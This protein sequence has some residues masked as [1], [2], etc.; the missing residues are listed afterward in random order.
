M[1]MWKDRLFS[2]QQPLWLFAALFAA[3]MVAFAANL[4]ANPSDWAAWVQAFGSI[5]A[6]VATAMVAVH[7]IN[8]ERKAAS[9]RNTAEHDAF[10]RSCYLAVRETDSTLRYISKQLSN[11]VGQRY[12]LGPER[13]ED[14]QETFRLLLGKQL[15]ADLVEDVLIVQRELAYT[16]LALKQLMKAH[17]VSPRRVDGASRRLATVNDALIRLSN[18]RAV[19]NWAADRPIFSQPPLLQ[20]DDHAEMGFE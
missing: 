10:V 4:P 20:D 2:V 7:Q 9:E 19:N 13:I 17:E 12:R 11:H 1:D 15:P 6:I 18:R 16:Q 8:T 5:G 3:L 14:L